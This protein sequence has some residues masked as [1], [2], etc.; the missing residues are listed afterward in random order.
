MDALGVRMDSVPVGKT[1]WPLITSGVAP[2]QAKETTAAAAAVTA[3]FSFA[4]LKPKR[5]TGRYELT[6]EMI[7]SV[8][9][10]ETALRRDLADAVKSKLSDI[11]INGQAPTT[12]N[13]QHIE[14][15]FNELTATD[16]SAAQAT[17]ADYGKLHAAAVDGIHAQTDQQVRSVIGD[18]NLPSLRRYVYHR[19]RRERFG[20]VDAPLR[21]V[22]GFHLH[23]RYCQQEANCDP[24][25]GWSARQSDAGRFGGGDVA[26]AGDRQRH[27]QPGLPRRDSDL[28]R[29]VGREGGVPSGY[30]QGDSDPDTGLI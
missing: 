29:S 28:G 6:H 24:A 21:W 19:K 13:P 4:N 1:E 17:A 11:I 12:Q 26:D 18:P 15:F 14:G 3:G 10:I 9:D 25:R 20:T 7:A 27:L 22:H 5:I 23:S 16:L 30:V 2:D 8:P